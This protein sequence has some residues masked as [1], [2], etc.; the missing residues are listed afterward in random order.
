MLG[1]ICPNGGD[2]TDVGRNVCGSGKRHTLAVRSAAERDTARQAR[3]MAY[4]RLFEEELSPVYGGKGAWDVLLEELKDKVGYKTAV[5][6]RFSIKK[7]W[8]RFIEANKELVAEGNALVRGK[9]SIDLKER[10]EIERIIDTFDFPPELEYLIG[11]YAA[12]LKDWIIDRSSGRREDSYT[13]NFAGVFISAKRPDPALIAQGIKKIFRQYLGVMWKG[14]GGTTRLIKG[15]P[16]EVSA[17]E[18]VAVVLQ[19]LLDFKASGTAMTDLYG[20]TTIEAVI[21][22]ASFAVGSRAESEIT[23]TGE[24]YANCTQYLFDKKRS[25]AFE[26]APLYEDMPDAFRLHNELF[27]SNAD[28]ERMF[29]IMRSLPLIDGKPS[30]MSKKQAMELFR[31]VS[32]LEDEIG[33]PL[34]IEWGFAEGEEV[35]YIIQMRPI[36][37]DFK[38]PLVAISPEMEKKEPFA[39]TPVALGHT[40]PEGFTGKVVMFGL[41]LDEPEKA[42]QSFE[43]KFGSEYI[44][45]QQDAASWVLH[46]TTKAR[47]L[48][49]PVYST[50]QAHNVNL[51][52]D[53]IS[54]G[55]FV[56]CNGP[57][58]RD[59]LMKDLHFKPVD[60]HPGVWVSDE[61]VTYF[62][63]GLKG[64]FF[65]KARSESDG[66]W[67]SEGTVEALKYSMFS[68]LRDAVTMPEAERISNGAIFDDVLKKLA[69][70]R[71]KEF[72]EMLKKDRSDGSESEIWVYA[73]LCRNIEE[74]IRC[75]LWPK[76]RA[77]PWLGDLSDCVKAYL[78]ELELYEARKKTSGQ[79]A[80]SPA[81]DLKVPFVGTPGTKPEYPEKLSV[82]VIHDESDADF[83]WDF[84]RSLGDEGYEFVYADCLA[85]ALSAAKTRRFDFITLDWMDTG[86][87]G[88]M[89]AIKMLWDKFHPYGIRAITLASTMGDLFDDLKRKAGFG[90]DCPFVLDDDLTDLVGA[91]RA[92]RTKQVTDY[93][94]ALKA[95]RSS[96]REEPV[97]PS[98][99]GPVKKKIRIL[100]VDDMANAREPLKW[101]LQLQFEQAEVHATGDGKEA[102]EMIAH[103]DYDII[104]ADVVVPDSY[105][106]TC[107]LKE[108]R[109]EIYILTGKWLDEA[110]K[111]TKEIAQKVTSYCL[112]PI[113]VEAVIFPAIQSMLQRVE[114]EAKPEMPKRAETGQRPVMMVMCDTPARTKHLTEHL[115]NVCG[116]D[117][118]VMAINSTE[119][120]ALA[121]EDVKPAIVVSDDMI[122]T[123]NVC[124]SVKELVRLHTTEAK[125]IFMSENAALLTRDAALL[126]PRYREIDILGFVEKPFH[127]K[128]VARLIK[129][130]REAYRIAAL[131]RAKILETQDIL[132]RM[133]PADNSAK[134]GEIRVW[135]GFSAKETQE[136]LLG[137]IRKHTEKGPYKVSFDDVDALVE[138]AC[139]Q[140]AAGNQDV[141]TILPYNK[142][143]LLQRKALEKAR[144]QIIYMMFPVDNEPGSQ[145]IVQVSGIVAAG[146]AY[147]NNDTEAFK[148]LYRIL[149]S[150]DA[151]LAYFTIERLRQDPS[152]L[153]FFLKPVAI[154]DY[155]EL[156][157]LNRLM[158]HVL[159]SA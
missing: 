112:K 56:Y 40:A 82:L 137:M 75:P 143:R 93:M 159:T 38:K 78:K 107:A 51:I 11:F 88:H 61:D 127:Y 134:T 109:A 103:G 7:L 46:S 151:D 91:I 18:G 94:A 33:V 150:G 35:P 69:L 125:F 68:V 62:S 44:R 50:R 90:P 86:L 98:G 79:A 31:I 83:R 8:G 25:G 95:W 66:N 55:E 52:D 99:E 34:D 54:A 3:A 71:L 12:G 81:V 57:V 122:G 5:S 115:G 4:Q 45:V 106:L 153:R 77:A 19:R 23:Q 133:R 59:G 118:S 67:A 30:P 155:G 154:A 80:E 24:G 41:G 15:M 149:S 110:E 113:D 39:S 111:L 148:A 139:Q 85:S 104:F 49:D 121:L 146:I 53:R 131:E 114:L 120:L 29:R 42:V 147:I 13:Y 152:L 22:D 14:Q 28:P 138:F 43:E 72:I 64:R 87:S 89:D 119:E 101:I 20:Y 116:G 105:D 140:A 1:L 126:I 36:I 157:R 6:I 158:E 145:S 58:L 63:D 124:G 100:I 128:D 136:R 10:I 123:R 84:A 76:K 108:S 21:G 9:D 27:D 26:W 102:A 73:D 97:R 156:T 47:V 60:G 117:Y 70:P 144:A 135:N 130:T 65:I 32:A 37:G 132:A 92:A 17:E 141:V 2:A 16:G 142:V 96:G 129:G 48:V 74:V